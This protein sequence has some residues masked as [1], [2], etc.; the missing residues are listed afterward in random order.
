MA[1][2]TDQTV[3]DWD[4]FHES[5][6]FEQEDYDP[7]DDDYFYRLAEYLAGDTDVHPGLEPEV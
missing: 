1:R 4:G 7:E 2:P 3:E 6:A 5:L